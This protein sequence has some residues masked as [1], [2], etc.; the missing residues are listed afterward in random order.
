MKLSARQRIKGGAENQ[1]ETVV[2]VVKVRSVS[3]R[4]R[5]K[6]KGKR[7][8]VVRGEKMISRNM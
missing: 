7:R 6:E 5:R 8:K 3:V 4:R 1:G 2:E